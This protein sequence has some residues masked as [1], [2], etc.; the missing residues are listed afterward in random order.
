MSY[1]FYIKDGKPYYTDGTK[2]Y[3]CSIAA[4]KT[5]V[6]FD[7]GTALVQSDVK[8]LLT[9][10]E[11]KHNLGIKYVVDWDAS[12]KKQI[13][14]SNQTVSSIPADPEEDE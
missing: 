12:N 1:G 5:T 13:K 4:D 8:C 11:V 7:S 6:K 2:S 9:E 14:V 10:A 3:P